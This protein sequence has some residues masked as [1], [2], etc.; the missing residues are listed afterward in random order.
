MAWHDFSIGT[1]WIGDSGRIIELHGVLLEK[2]TFPQLVKKSPTFHG[3]GRFI[4]VFTTFRL[5]YL[6]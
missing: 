6:S 4:T 5:R 2:L 3:A 1:S